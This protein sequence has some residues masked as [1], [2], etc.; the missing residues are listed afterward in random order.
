MK[1]SNSSAPERSMLVLLSLILVAAV[2]NLNLAVA[3]VALP[4]I[5][6]EFDSGQTALNLIAVGYSL[7]LAASVLYFGAIGD[8]YGRK[9]ML[10][11]GM[12]LSIPA[13]L[14]AAWAPTDEVLFARAP[15]GRALRRHG[16][17]DDARADHG[18]LVGA[19]AHEGD[20]PVVGHRRRHLLARPRAL[21]RAVGALLVGLGLPD[22]LAARRGR[23]R[24][25]RAVRAEPR[26]RGERPGRQPRRDP[27]RRPRRGAR[28]VD[29]LRARS[30][31]GNLGLGLGSRR[32][33][34][35][36][37]VPDP[38]ASRAE[39]ALRPAGGRAP[40]LLGGCLA[41]G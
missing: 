15:P 7:G 29:Q 12:A 22:H 34:G 26:Q 21:R 41:R 13:C 6:K 32:R 3:N 39:P 10:I 4:S 19:R 36:D 37:R 40:R 17:P 5:A 31:Q 14:L 1:D 2:A 16:V 23:A 24:D 33:R 20:R 9:L 8:R 35:P 18:A 27:V 30:G 11:L 38:P 25:G 28:P